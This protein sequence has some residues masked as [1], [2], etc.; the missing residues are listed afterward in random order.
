MTLRLT[1]QGWYVLVRGECDSMKDVLRLSRVAP[2]QVLLDGE[3]REL[4]NDGDETRTYGHNRFFCVCWLPIC[5]N[6]GSASSSN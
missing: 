3:V 5:L 1:E 2:M 4:Y 6:M